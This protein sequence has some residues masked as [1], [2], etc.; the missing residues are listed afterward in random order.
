MSHATPTE[1]RPNP[2]NGSAAM[3]HAA[4]HES[5]TTSDE[6]AKPAELRDRDGASH[7]TGTQDD[8]VSRAATLAERCGSDVG[9]HTD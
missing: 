4:Q 8:N 1:S 9:C 6:Q 5:Q 2:L 3:S 7:T